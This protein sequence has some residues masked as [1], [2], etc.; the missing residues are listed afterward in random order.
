MEKFNR[1]KLDSAQT[2]A[3]I[4]MRKEKSVF[5]ALAVKAERLRKQ[6]KKSSKNLFK[7]TAPKEDKLCVLVHVRGGIGDVAMSR[8]FMSKLHLALPNAKIDFCFDSKEVF[9]MIF[10]D[11]KFTVSFVLRNYNPKNYDLVIAGSHSFSFDYY[12]EERIKKLAPG[13]WQ[14]FQ[15]GLA[16]QKILDVYTHNPPQLDGLLAHSTVRYGSARV[17]NLGLSTGLDIKQNDRAPIEL[18][19][20]GFKILKTLGLEGKKYITIHD[21]TNSNTDISKGYPPRA[22]PKEHWREFTRLF[23]AAF[24]DIT[25]VQIGGS[26]STVFDFVDVSIVGKTRVADLPY[27]LQKSVLHIDT[28]SGMVHLAHLLDTICVVM[29]GPSI[30]EYLAYERNINITAPSCGNC[31]NIT[32]DWI[33]RCILN[34]PQS[35]ACMASI[36]PQTVFER[37]QAYLK[38]A[39]KKDL[40]QI[41][42][43]IED[44]TALFALQTE[45]LINY[46]AVKSGIVRVAY[47]LDDF[48]RA[49]NQKRKNIKRDIQ[50]FFGKKDKRNILKVLIHT[51]GGIG[52]LCMNGRFFAQIKNALPEAEITLCHEKRNVIE[53]LFSGGG[54]ISDFTGNRYKRKDYDLVL[55]GSHVYNFDFY[56]LGRIKKL[57]PGFLPVFERAL[58]RQ[59][60]FRSFHLYGSLLDGIL[61]NFALDNGFNNFNIMGFSAGLDTELP[62]WEPFKN[63]LNRDVLQKYGLKEKEYITV[64]DGIGDCLAGGHN[65]PTRSWPQENWE[66]LILKLKQKYPQYK[67]V[68][69]GAGDNPFFKGVDINLIN[70]TAFSELP[71]LLQGS[72]LHFDVESGMSHMAGICG[73]HS[74]IM[75]GSSSE[76]YFSYPSNI[77]IHAKNCGNCM[78]ILQEWLNECVLKNNPQCM[79]T[80]AV[81]EVF[82]SAQK[83]LGV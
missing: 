80:I 49:L 54:A 77:N 36:T 26:N 65:R 64:H 33:S 58:Q 8:V 29:F 1:L 53:T 81:E 35:K 28:E 30:K 38:N 24:P 48:K 25:V 40:T 5:I 55:S 6:L 9:N 44:K 39:E 11:G 41:N 79:Q 14:T 66:G 15:K 12:E 50:Y 32:G 3:I 10:L 4:N 72:K 67:I 83:T 45:G 76:Q 17:A 68:Q 61:S 75:Y 59:K 56:K 69:L 60:A 42:Y 34:K 7:K 52:D 13:F 20:D 2:K 74:I 51:R 22:W 63:K 43:S 71:S 27:I 57:A 70:K 19:E 46:C 16:M 21:G 73:A 18:K 62:A 47:K 23:K 31:M 82:S 78:W 37:A